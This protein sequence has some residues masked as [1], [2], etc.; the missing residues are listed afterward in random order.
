MFKFD[1]HGLII[2]TTCFFSLRQ[3]TT[4]VEKT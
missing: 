2:D 3:I 1:K 4:Q